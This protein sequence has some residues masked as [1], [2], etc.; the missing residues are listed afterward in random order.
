[1]QYYAIK[2]TDRLLRFDTTND[3]WTVTMLPFAQTPNAPYE[4]QRTTSGDG[5]TVEIQ[6]AGNSGDFLLPTGDT[7]LILDDASETV[8]IKIPD[9]GLS[10]AYVSWGGTTGGS[11]GGGTVITPAPPVTIAID[12]PPEVIPRA[13]GKVEIFIIWSPSAS[14]TSSNFSGV[15]VYVEDPDISSG[16]TAPLDS[17]GMKLDG[18][19]QLSGGWAPVFYNNF[20]PA[21]SGQSVVDVLLDAKAGDRDVRFYLAAYGPN[22]QAQPV[23]ANQTNPTPNVMVDVPGATFG[24]SGEEYAWLVTG[25]TAVVTT[26]YNRP[27]P[28]Y[29]LTLGY[30]QPDA[31]IPVPSNR[32]PFAGCRIIYVPLDSDGNPQFPGSDSGIFIPTKSDAGFK[33]PVYTPSP[34][35]MQFRCYFCSQDTLGNINSLV[36]GVTP[37][38]D[39]S[40]PQVAPAPDVTNFQIV[41]TPSVEY[42]LDGS[43]IEQADLS[44]S[45]PTA[46]AGG[47]RYAGVFLYL[48]NVTGTAPLT[49]FPQVLTAQQPNAEA[50]FILTIPAPGAP[51]PAATETWTIAAISVDNNGVLADDPKKFGQSTFHSP[52]VTWS[53]GPPQPGTPGGGQEFAPLVSITTPAV[54]PTE[55]LS[56][57]GVRMVSFAVGAWSNPTSNQFGGAQVA[58]VVNNDP[59]KPTYW[60]VPKNA[61][62][63]T[64]PA[65]PAMGTVGAAVETDF[66]IVSDDPQGHKNSLQ[67]GKTPVIPYKYTPTAGAV[68]PARSGWFDP[69]QFA[70]DTSGQFQ[71]QAFSASII[72][73]GSKLIVGGAPASF[74]GNSNGQIAVLD[75]SGTLLDWFGKQQPDQVHAGQSNPVW[76]AWLGQVYIGGTSPLDAPVF[77]NNTGIIVV[78]GISAVTGIGNPTANN[79]A[80]PYISV[81]DDH[82]IEMGRIGSKLNVSSGTAGDGVGSSPPQLT[83]GAWFTQLGIGGSSISNW[84]VLI[85]PDATNPLGSNFQMRNI[86]LLSIDYAANSGAAPYNKEYKLEFGHAVWMAAGLSGATWQ[87]PGTHVYEVD[88]NSASDQIHTFGATFISRGVILRGTVNQAGLKSYPV[89]VSLVQYNGD[90]TGSDD[91][92]PYFYGELTMFNPKVLNQVSIDLS[93]GTPNGSPPS[94]TDTNPYFAMFDANGNRVFW[95]DPKGGTLQAKGLLQ[96]IGG[97][98]INAIAYNVNSKPVI[99]ANGNWVGNAISGGGQPQTPWAQNIQG[100]GWNLSGVNSISCASATISGLATMTSLGVGTGGGV[101][102]TGTLAS[103]PASALQVSGGLAIGNNSGVTL[104][105]AEVWVSGIRVIDTNGIYYGRG[106]QCGTNDVFAGLFGIS[107]IALGWPQTLSSPAP[108]GGGT[109]PQAAQ[110]TSQSF[111]TGDGRTVWVCGGI[112]VNVTTP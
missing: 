101:I 9:N 81:R 21:K 45:L 35:G 98:P 52:T 40:V 51:I 19:A 59:T 103:A 90:T 43:I 18:S 54:T 67:V 25:Q 14:A 79:A 102:G 8:Y 13:D 74:G 70:W 68:I 39:V 28:N 75:S 93:A 34:A 50:S 17:G 88:A 76:G 3:S 37:Y 42:L 66:Y 23:R 104:G 112:I 99:D 94:D 20:P 64:T 2:V 106:V 56:A 86:Y 57:D 33:S 63:F 29:Y 53:V 47:A 10:P 30:T 1:M 83:A 32:R 73:V 105:T 82:G 49:A 84:N 109:P 97:V 12:P 61:T 4:I 11:G 62:S 95:V 85:T 41:G 65:I 108:P 69:T 16:S 110:G 77:V 44:W 31:S 38:A 7:S 60:S 22:T 15:A 78:G 89:L 100:A 48:V 36:E 27:D 111:K 91:S 72:Q 58:M 26:D 46:A 24:N 5:N 55:S 80:Y 87:F 107:N 92:N 6:V 96:G 71:G